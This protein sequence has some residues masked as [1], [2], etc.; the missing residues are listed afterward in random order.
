MASSDNS[1]DNF[2]GLKR[3]SPLKSV[4]RSA[5][6][7]PH[8]LS[9]GLKK[10]TYGIIMAFLFLFVTIRQQAECKKSDTPIRVQW[11]LS[12]NRVLHRVPPT[13]VGF[14]MDWN[15][16]TLDPSWTSASLIEIDL[17]NLMLRQFASALAPAVLRVGG[18]LAD[19]AKYNV[20]HPPPEDCPRETCLTM[21]RWTELV[22]FAKETGLHLLFDVRIQIWKR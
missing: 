6:D 17:Q 18:F 16:G 14:T 11:Q 5:N 7:G 20:G 2:G 9:L 1:N 21:D 22:N 8:H 10:K 12:P 4:R 3:N 19:V 15:N 13:F